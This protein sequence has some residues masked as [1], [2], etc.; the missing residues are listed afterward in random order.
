VKG[1]SNV[2][3]WFATYNVEFVAAAIYLVEW[4]NSV[5]VTPMVVGS[6]LHSGGSRRRSI[7]AA[8]GT[9]V[10]FVVTN[11]HYSRTECA[12]ESAKT[13]S[14]SEDSNAFLRCV[15]LRLLGTCFLGKPVFDLAKQL[16]GFYLKSC[17]AETKQ[18][19]NKVSAFKDISHDHNVAIR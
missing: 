14:D 18:V 7:V 16:R 11:G 13:T 5:A 17:V 9:I 15:M 2:A 8:I 12:G 4:G 10:P 6:I 1:R 3:W 19:G